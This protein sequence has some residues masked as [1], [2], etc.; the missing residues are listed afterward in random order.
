MISLRT[1]ATQSRPY[2][3]MYRV[4]LS[5]LAQPRL[6]GVGQPYQRQLGQYAG[7]THP[8]DTGARSLMLLSA[9]IRQGKSI[10]TGAVL[11]EN[12]VT[13]FVYEYHPA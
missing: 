5:A 7:L 13:P 2:P 1:D 6:T 3:S 8:R 12:I 4:G 11:N 10:A 9:H